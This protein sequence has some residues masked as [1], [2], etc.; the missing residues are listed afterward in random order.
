MLIFIKDMNEAITCLSSSQW[1]ERRDGLVNLKNMMQTGRVFSRQE[2]KRLCEIFSRLFQD[3]HNKVR[4]LN[5]TL[6]IF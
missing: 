3:Q 2:L 6:V 4:N 1:S 5:I